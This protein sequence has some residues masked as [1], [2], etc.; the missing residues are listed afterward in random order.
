LLFAFAF[1]VVLG[2][3]VHAQQ[4]DFSLVLSSIRKNVDSVIEETR[5][6]II[7]PKG[8]MEVPSREQR[9]QTQI[10]CLQNSNFVNCGGCDIRGIF[11]NTSSHTSPVESIPGGTM[12]MNYFDQF[13]NRPNNLFRRILKIAVSFN[14]QV[15]Q[16][17]NFYQ[18]SQCPQLSNPS[19]YP[20]V[21]A[22]AI[23]LEIMG[24]YSS[25]TECSF[26]IGDCPPVCNDRSFTMNLCENPLASFEN[27]CEQFREHKGGA[28]FAFSTDCQL[29][30]FVPSTTDVSD[31]S[32]S[33]STSSDSGSGLGASGSSSPEFEM[34]NPIYKRQAK[35]ISPP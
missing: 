9:R 35:A 11:L 31:G 16:L 24:S 1:C 29:L 4:I 20:D 19:F 13:N 17:L 22:F 6:S 27:S 10:N 15:C 33:F 18:M 32:S 25:P 30:T 21:T 5:N 28:P 8:S 12:T 3:E 2:D 26:W 34:E 23:W 14:S 7:P